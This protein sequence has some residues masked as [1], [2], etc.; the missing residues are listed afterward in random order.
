MIRRIRASEQ[1][2]LKQ[3]CESDKHWRQYF[4][5]HENWTKV[6]LADAH[7]KNR[8]VYGAF[9]PKTTEGDNVSNELIG[10]L[11]LKHSKFD[12]SI[13]FKNLILPAYNF[14]DNL[15]VKKTARKLIESAIR[16]CEVRNI[17][18][19]EVELPQKEHNLI[20]IFLSF[21]FKIITVRERYNLG[22]SVCTMERFVG[23]KFYGDP[24]DIHKLAQWFLKSYIAADTNSTSIEGDFSRIS[25]TCKPVTSAFSTIGSVGN[26]KLPKGELW[27]FSDENHVEDDVTDEDQCD[28]D[29]PE[30]FFDYDDSIDDDFNEKDIDYIV[31]NSKRS[32][33]TL[34]LTTLPL[35]NTS[36][37][38]LEIEGIIHFD[39]NE[40][41]EIT[42]GEK[43]SLNIPTRKQNLGGVITVLE[44]EQILEYAQM[45]SLTYYLLSGLHSGLDFPDEGEQMILAIYCAKWKDKNAGIVGFGIIKN[46]KR[47]PFSKILK[48]NLPP[49]SALSKEDLAFYQTFSTDEHIAAVSLSQLTLFEK[50]LPIIGGEWAAP[51]ERDYLYNQIITNGC[52]SAYLDSKSKKNILKIAEKKGFQMRDNPVN[53]KLK[54][55]KKFRIGIS[56]PGEH[57]D[58]VEKVAKILTAELGEGSVF[59]DNDYQS[60]LGV[61]DLDIFIGQIFEENCEL[62]VTFFSQHYL[63]KRW[64]KIEW[65]YIR[66]AITKSEDKSVLRAFFFEKVDI[67]GRVE[68]DGYE[69]IDNK[70]P[71]SVAN[72]ILKTLLNP[73]KLDKL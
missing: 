33:L 17:H 41:L 5:Q 69:M 34:L 24:F 42:G 47:A 15:D 13:E 6:A 29:D 43:S 21:N 64:C 39:K 61:E 30:V 32:N 44:Q 22:N 1:E 71:R 67:P 68:N 46:V 27:I 58:Y 14:E 56:F 52:N 2:L 63:K 12:S 25:F 70:T 53:V 37:E 48:G 62:I 40:L 9:E 11:F 51:V 8:V 45:K 18:K 73:L 54:K 7:D 55:Q 28:Y 10:C 57:R 31:N 4:N 50:P 49:D 59:Y 66:S 19:I 20:S 65:K 38:K 60:D 35:S 16:F 3:L 36:K 23:E 72:S 26:D